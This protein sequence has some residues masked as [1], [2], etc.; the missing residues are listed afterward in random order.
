MNIKIENI[1][2][3]IKN[4]KTAGMGHTDMIE[5]A[6]HVLMEVESTF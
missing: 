1:Y 6:N 4:I 2:K 5:H 3:L